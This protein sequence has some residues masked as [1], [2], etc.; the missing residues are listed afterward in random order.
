MYSSFKTL[1][2]RSVIFSVRLPARQFWKDASVWYRRR[3]TLGPMVFVFVLSLPAFPF[4]SSV[5]SL[6]GSIRGEHH[7]SKIRFMQ[8]LGSLGQQDSFGTAYIRLIDTFAHFIDVGKEGD[9][10]GTPLRGAVFIVQGTDGFTL[11]SCNVDYGHTKKEPSLKD[12]P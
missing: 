4:F 5:K 12:S 3:I 7:G 1:F 6:F 8:S 10:A 2:L 9:V 11:Q